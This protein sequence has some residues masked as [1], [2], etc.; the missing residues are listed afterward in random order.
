MGEVVQVRARFG[1]S[2]IMGGTICA[3]KEDDVS[4]CSSKMLFAGFSNVR[5]YRVRRRDG[6]GKAFRGLP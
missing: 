1:V 2:V 3:L 5:L 6:L 4:F